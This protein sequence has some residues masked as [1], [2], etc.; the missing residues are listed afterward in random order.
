MNGFD[1]FF[2]GRSEL[3]GGLA[4]IW[5]NG[6]YDG[7]IGEIGTVLELQVTFPN[8]ELGGCIFWVP[9]TFDS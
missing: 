8:M 4:V 7:C 2:G 6:G 3:L 5:E 1:A 9:E